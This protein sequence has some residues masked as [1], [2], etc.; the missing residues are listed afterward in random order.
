MDWSV[1][2][3]RGTILNG[4]G[5]RDY[6]RL[7]QSGGQLLY[8]ERKFPATNGGPCYQQMYRTASKIVIALSEAEEI[9]RLSEVK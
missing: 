8:K 4:D 7:Q 3:T 2:V 5:K 9:M 6:V 1:V